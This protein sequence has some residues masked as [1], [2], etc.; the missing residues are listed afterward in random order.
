M[1]R[2]A[3]GRGISLCRGPIGKPDKGL[4][5]RGLM[6]RRQLWRWAPL[7]IGATLGHVGGGGSVH[8]EL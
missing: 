4:I 1:G 5:Y 6:C 8:R 3:K 7:S 2:R